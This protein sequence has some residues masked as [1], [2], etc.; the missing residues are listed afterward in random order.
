MNP[1]YK[2]FLDNFNK[3]YDEF[4]FSDDWNEGLNQLLSQKYNDIQL[5]A[6]TARVVLYGYYRDLAIEKLPEKKQK[7]VRICIENE[8]K[9]MAEKL[10]KER[11]EYQPQIVVRT[12]EEQDAIDAKL[13]EEGKFYQ[14][15]GHETTDFED[16]QIQELKEKVQKLRAE[17]KLEEAVE[18][19]KSSVIVT[20]KDSDKTLPK[21]E[22]VEENEDK[23]EPVQK[24]VKKQESIMTAM[25][26]KVVKS[27]NNNKLKD[28]LKKEEYLI[29]GNTHE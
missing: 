2:K 23:V 17:G 11:E 19:L 4:E 22:E 26:N 5:D 10:K 6:D 28:V 16:Q 25:K 18:L 15:E 24:K 20:E 21:I 1:T 3:H 29:N 13:K 12:K 7:L 9:E 14:I 27:Q 8:E